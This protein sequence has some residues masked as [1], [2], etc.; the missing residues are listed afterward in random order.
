VHILNG[1]S[2][3]HY[4]IDN[5][6]MKIWIPL[7]QNI[8][9]KTM[10]PF[11]SIQPRNIVFLDNLEHCFSTPTFYCST[12]SES[13][14]KKCSPWQRGSNS[15]TKYFRSHDT[16]I[17]LYYFFYNIRLSVYLILKKLATLCF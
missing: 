12:T 2:S 9:P 11:I 17:L 14:R 5:N 13:G 10:G 8:T 16:H 7:T 6:V 15:L 3:K 4:T 1:I